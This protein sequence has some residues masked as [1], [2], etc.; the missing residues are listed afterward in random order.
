MNSLSI[1][2]S[3]LLRRALLASTILASICSA[4][5]GALDSASDFRSPPAAGNPEQCRQLIGQTQAGSNRDAFDPGDIQIL[6]WNLQKGQKRGWQSDLELLA[7][8][9]Q[10]VMIQEAS[11]DAAMTDP[12]GPARFAAF[13][14]GYR[15]RSSITGVLTLSEV[16]PLAHCS[17]TSH[18]PWL[19]TPKATSISEYALNGSDETLVVVNIHAVNFT[20][21][22]SDY[23]RQLQQIRTALQDHRGPVIMTGDFNSWRLRRQHLLQQ[24]VDDL[25]L[26]APEY[27]LDNRVRVFGHAI[28]HI[29]IRGFSSQPAISPVVTSSDHNPLVVR[30]GLIGGSS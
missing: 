10:L 15:T 22:V 7:A 2:H 16:M 23:R 4:K 26:K 12:G 25:G 11:L 28:D 19:G 14:P 8:R 17:L 30:L 13:A 1:T 29:Y 18:E 21:G 27:K 6:N 5:A 20:F 24:L 9:S 3:R